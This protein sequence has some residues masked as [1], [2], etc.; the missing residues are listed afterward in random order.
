MP[1]LEKVQVPVVI[2]S[3]L[4]NLFI[5]ILVGTLLNNTVSLYNG[6][7]LKFIPSL[8]QLG[9]T[10]YHIVTQLIAKAQF[11]RA[12]GH[13][14]DLLKFIQ[15]LKTWKNYDNK[16]MDKELGT[17]ALRA[18]DV[19]LLGAGKLE[20]VKVTPAQRTSHLC[21]V[22]DWRRLSLLFQAEAI[23]HSSL[24]SL[25]DR[26]LKC[27]RKYQVD[28][29][30]KHVNFKSLA[31]FFETIFNALV[32]KLDQLVTNGRDAMLLLVELGFHYGRICNKAGSP[33]EALLVFDK[34]L[35]TAGNVHQCKNGQSKLHVPSQVCCCVCLVCKTVISLNC[36]EKT[37]TQDSNQLLLDTNRLVFQLLKCKSLPSPLLKL[38]SDS[39]EFFRI[40]LQNVCNKQKDS[41]KEK[42]L[43]LSWRTFQE[44]VQLLQAYITVLSLQCKQFK[45]ELLKADSDDLAAQL[46]QQ[47]QKTTEQ[48]L[49]VLSFVISSYQDQLKNEKNAKNTNSESRSVV[50]L[51]NVNSS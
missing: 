47:L 8:D 51:F 6:N 17:L 40:T 48:Q 44:V 26:T 36:V 50:K 12:F 45:T 42:S 15:L 23:P 14:S 3:L 22:L 39:L 32:S 10:L 29:G 33:I 13:A 37:Q 30:Q 16:K 46:R 9:K 19:L 18:S 34:L 49:S 1:G 21:V 4:T 41:S 25:V 43:A 28:C 2:L 31:S 11:D 38:L 35:E 7:Y 5:S 24:K 27:G 20:E